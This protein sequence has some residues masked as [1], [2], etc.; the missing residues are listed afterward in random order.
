MKDTSSTDDWRSLCE[1]ASKETNPQKLL[2]LITRINRAL[3]ECHR[4]RR[5]A[6]EAS[7][8]ADTVLPLVSKSRQYDFD[9]YRLPG[10][11]TVALEYDC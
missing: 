7:F 5:Q 1:L 11:C 9:L 10:E 2:E 3:E 4:P 8:R 6:D